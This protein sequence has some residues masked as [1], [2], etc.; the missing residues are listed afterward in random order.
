[1]QCVLQLLTTRQTAASMLAAYPRFFGRSLFEGLAIE[2]GEPPAPA[3]MEH[4]DVPQC[5]QW[6]DVT[7]YVS[8][9]MLHNM[10]GHVPFIATAPQPSAYP[11]GWSGLS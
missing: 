5:L 6:P 3:I 10:S 8:K 9:L 1:M 11:G 2:R 7:S 4:H